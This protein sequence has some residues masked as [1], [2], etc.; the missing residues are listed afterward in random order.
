VAGARR[1]SFYLPKT[2]KSQSA[3]VILP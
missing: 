3:P 1:R 2:V